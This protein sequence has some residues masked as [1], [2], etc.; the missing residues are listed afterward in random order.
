[1]TSQ[2]LIGIQARSTSARFPN[3]HMELLGGQ[4]ILDHVLNAC[5]GAAGYLNARVSLFGM[6]VQ[7]VLLTP[8]DDPLSYAFSP[9]CDVFQGPEHDVLTRYHMA[10]EHYAPHY[11][12]R[13]T[14]DCPLIPQYVI[15]KMLMLAVKNRY[16]Y[17]SNV[18]PAVRTAED[19]I[20]CEVMSRRMLDWLNE[21]AGDALHR[22]HV[23]SLVTETMPKWA[24]LGFMTGYFDRSDVKISVDT[25]EDLARVRLVEA[26]RT[27]KYNAA[28]K[29]YGEG[30]VHRV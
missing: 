24:N 13:V 28:K 8:T 29:R 9:K 18:D 7:T 14:G 25:P 12:C 26:S 4:M 2:V 16:D 5:L 23:T 19:G 27:M 11:I 30:K 21:R 1:M 15:S 3:K 6:R 22:E 20:D 17:V 10:A